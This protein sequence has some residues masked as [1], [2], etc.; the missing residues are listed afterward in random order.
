MVAIVGA[1]GAGKTTITQLLLRLYLRR[2]G[3]IEVDG[4]DLETLSLRSLRTGIGVV[5]QDVFLFADTILENVRLFDPAL[6]EE[7]VRRACETVGAARFIERLPQG[8]ATPLGERGMNLSAGQRQL[9]AFARVLVHDP[10]VLIL[11]E[12]TSS[13][14]TE[15]ERLLQAAVERVLAGRTC[16][17]IAHRLSTIRRADQIVVL[18]HGRLR[19]RGTHAELVKQDGIYARLH[20]LQFAQD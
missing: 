3:A 7:A 2:A 19:E 11:D 17:V 13:I 12:A 18:H 1:T 20:A 10:A 16:L 5:P 8:Y 4:L 6:R 14:D 15:S 9:L